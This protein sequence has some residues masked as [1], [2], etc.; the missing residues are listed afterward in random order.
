MMKPT[1]QNATTMVVTVAGI[2]S[3]QN[4][5]QNVFAIEEGNQHVTSNVSDLFMV[6]KESGQSYNTVNTGCESNISYDDSDDDNDDEDD[7]DDGDGD[8]GESESES[9]D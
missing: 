5:V 4:T 6:T 3:V 2:V 1:M 8:E 9:D 7:G